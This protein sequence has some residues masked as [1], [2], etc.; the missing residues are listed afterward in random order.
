MSKAK[1]TA[2]RTITGVVEVPGDKS[3][4]HRYAILAA[5][6]RGSSEIH[7]Y[8]TAADCKSTLKCLE[9]LGIEIEFGE[10]T[11]RITGNGL[12]GLKTPRRTLDAGNSGTTMRLLTGVLAGQDFASAIS[13]DASLRRR[14]M[15]RIIEPLGAMG[16]KITPS[17]GGRAPL[18]IRGTQLHSIDYALPIPSAQVKSAILLAGLFAE[19]ETS[20]REPIATRDHLELALREF[21]ARVAA[22]KE[23]I[24]VH[25]GPRLEARNLAVPGDLSSAVFFIAAA[26]ILPGSSVTIHNVGLNPTRT[27]ILDFLIAMG[28]PIHVASLQSMAGEL[29]GDLAVHHG[30]I[31]G[32]EISGAQVAEM[33]DELPML[34]ALAPFTEKGIEIRGAQELRVK[35]SDRI[36]ALAELLGRMGA[37]VEE[38]PDGLRVAGRSAG[39]LHGA[40]I[41]PQGDHRIAMA[42]AIAGLGA[43]GTTVVQNA[44][45]AAVSFPNF[46]ATIERM[47]E[48]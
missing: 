36:A 45:C 42:L 14:P 17:D 5:L 30:P 24:R 22:G 6:A 9:R 27:R 12:R 37:R 40:K 3:I 44:E 31:S 21:G 34:A 38:F 18:Q 23:G 25:G 39:K 16:A 10:R 48:R 43:E 29:V 35:E 41:D 46:F 26:L 33:I 2:A 28:A 8:S 32:G 7:N 1:I 13:G 15:R 47:V 20:V 11:V 19:G 4:S